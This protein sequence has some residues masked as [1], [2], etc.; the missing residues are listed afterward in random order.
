MATRKVFIV[1]PYSHLKPI[2]RAARKYGLLLEYVTPSETEAK[3]TRM[4]D[5]YCGLTPLPLVVF[6]RLPIVEGPTVYT[7]DSSPSVVIETGTGDVCDCEKII[8]SSESVA[9]YMYIKLAVNLL[10]RRPPL[11]TRNAETVRDARSCRAFIGDKGIIL[12]ALRK[13]SVIEVADIYKKATGL[14]PVFAATAGNGCPRI[15]TVLRKLYRARFTLGDV[16]QAYNRLRIPLHYIEYYFNSI[17]LDYNESLIMQNM[18]LLHEYKH[19][20]N[21]HPSTR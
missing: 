9:A 5:E 10:C 18:E 2:V 3:I 14:Y 16:L 20:I 19:L 13:G 6:Y 8:V 15:G 7:L 1:Q 21:P 4:N 17:H 12:Y 11:V